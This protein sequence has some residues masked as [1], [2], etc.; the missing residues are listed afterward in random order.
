MK[1][2]EIPVNVSNVGMPSLDPVS[3]M[4]MNKL[5]L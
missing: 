5:T 3:F 1:G 4:G 2:L